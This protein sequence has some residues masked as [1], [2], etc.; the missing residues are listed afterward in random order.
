[1]NCRKRAAA[2]QLIEKYY[3]QLTDGCG[4][5]ECTN[6]HCASSSRFVLPNLS[7]DEAAAQALQFFK[8]KAR[9][10]EN[11]PP[12]KVAKVPEN[13]ENVKE[14]EAERPSTSTSTAGSRNNRDH[15]PKGMTDLTVY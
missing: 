4:N 9:L 1:V 2:R 15:V 5:P 7:R 10:C 13:V 14:K 11:N 12:S 8:E 3:Y 6:E